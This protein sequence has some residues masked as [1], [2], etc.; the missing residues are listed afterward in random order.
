MVSFSVISTVNRLSVRQVHE[1]FLV[2][3]VSG[4]DLGLN[5]Y[6]AEWVPRPVS[7]G[8]SGGGVKLN[9]HCHLLPKYTT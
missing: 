8:E 5:T 3:N 2:A 7:P 1:T 6:S 9:V 4:V